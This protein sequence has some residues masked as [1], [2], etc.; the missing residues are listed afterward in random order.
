MN[1]FMKPSTFHTRI[2][3]GNGLT[4]I[5]LLPDIARGKDA[6]PNTVEF[7]YDT[8]WNAPL[9]ATSAVAKWRNRPL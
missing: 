9:L 8:F 2:D 4:Q 3:D 6:S 1:R 5:R 7:E